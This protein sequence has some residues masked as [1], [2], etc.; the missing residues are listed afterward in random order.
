M[1][2]V[3]GVRLRLFLDKSYNV[4]CKV[5]P[6]SPVLTFAWARTNIRG[7]PNQLN[8]LSPPCKAE[9]RGSKV[10]TKKIINVQ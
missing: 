1:F 2:Y 8:S 4:S 9:E 7:E 6:I 5:C 10:G 3:K